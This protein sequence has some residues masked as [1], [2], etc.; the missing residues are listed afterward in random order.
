MSLVQPLV[1]TPVASSTDTPLSEVVQPIPGAVFLDT[2]TVPAGPAP[3]PLVD[4]IFGD[5][6]FYESIAQTYEIDADGTAS[7]TGSAELTRQLFLAANGAA[8]VS[9][10]ASLEITQYISAA[11]AATITGSA[12][13]VQW[14]DISASAAA[15]V[16]GS[17]AVGVLYYLT[18]D[19]TVAITGTAEIL[20]S[21]NITASGNATISGTAGI[22]HIH[23]LAATGFVAV[24]GS[25]G[26]VQ[27]LIIIAAGQSSVTGTAAILRIINYYPLRVRDPA[28]RAW[29]LARLRVKTR[30]DEPW[31]YVTAKARKPAKPD[32]WYWFAGAPRPGVPA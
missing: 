15:T 17:A 31:V 12:S 14:L 20:R 9:G 32:E 10:S 19:G 13:I 28:T 22:M 3:A 30:Y 11:G 7:V 26:I 18:A 25:A 29:V 6:V 24:A 16:T 23:G 2:G 4:S 1:Q 8:T 5:P 27:R 21:L